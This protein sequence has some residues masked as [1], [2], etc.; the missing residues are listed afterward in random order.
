MVNFKKYVS[1]QFILYGVI[2]VSGVTI[3][4]LT[5]YLFVEYFEINYQIANWLSTSLGILN[6]FFLNAYLN[7]GKTDR[8]L[9]R[10]FKFYAIGLL[11]LLITALLLFIMIEVVGV[12]AML[13]KGLS[14]FVVVLVQYSLNKKISFGDKAMK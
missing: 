14:I 1:K 13:A 8:L 7:F 11:G 5:F 4:F 2:G 12:N 10:L 9:I 3:D 6:N